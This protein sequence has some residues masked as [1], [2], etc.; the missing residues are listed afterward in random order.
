MNCGTCRHDNEP[1]ARFCSE[2]GATLGLRC[3]EYE[4]VDPEAART[5]LAP[6]FEVLK[7]TIEEHRKLSFEGGGVAELASATSTMDLVDHLVIPIIHRLS[8]VAVL[9]EQHLF[10][11]DGN[12][13]AVLA[14]ATWLDGL[15]RTFEAFDLD[16]VEHA[17]AHYDELVGAS[18]P[19]GT[20]TLANRATRLRN[21]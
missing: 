21:C 15:V 14:L 9:Y 13:S 2:C 7:S 12:T 8:E 18:S 5:A 3:P 6:Y 11:V 20:G 19:A 16:D 1:N 10:D 4:R 17:L